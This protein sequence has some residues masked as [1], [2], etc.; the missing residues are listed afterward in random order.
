MSVY[1]H[2]KVAWRDEI[3]Q[4]TLFPARIFI[5]S[6]ARIPDPLSDDSLFDNRMYDCTDPCATACFL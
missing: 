5:N 1:T 6:T 3:N 4:L 2:Q